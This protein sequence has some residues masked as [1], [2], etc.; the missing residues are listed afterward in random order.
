MKKLNQ[1]FAIVLLLAL[2]CFVVSAFSLFIASK[3]NKEKNDTTVATSTDIVATLI[4]AA[5]PTDTTTIDPNAA[6][7][8]DP[9]STTNNNNNTTTNN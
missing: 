1:S 9:N 7:T 6:N 8:T 2:L 3:T 4:D 5:T